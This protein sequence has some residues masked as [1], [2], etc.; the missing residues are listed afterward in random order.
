M[1]EPLFVVQQL[2][3][4]AATIATKTIAEYSDVSTRE[5]H[6]AS[7]LAVIFYRCLLLY[8]GERWTT[9]KLRTNF[10]QVRRRE[11]GNSYDT[12]TYHYSC[13][14]IRY[15]EADEFCCR[16]S[17][18]SA[19]FVGEGAYQTR[20]RALRKVRHLG[21]VARSSFTF[22]GGFCSKCRAYSTAEKAKVYDKLI[23]RK[24]ERPL[25]A[26]ETVILLEDLKDGKDG[27][28]RMKTFHY[29][30]KARHPMSSL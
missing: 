10:H 15:E 28:N 27:L 20:L 22:F 25:D 19:P 12:M 14:G 7:V 4:V 18:L 24:S 5:K 9:S 23:A 30:F 3:T 11:F 17:L 26:T 21:I 6:R 2:S 13:S 8:A 1:D 16:R 29:Y